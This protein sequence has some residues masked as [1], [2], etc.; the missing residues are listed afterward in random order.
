MMYWQKHKMKTLKTLNSVLFLV[1][2]TMCTDH[3]ISL[4]LFVRVSF[5]SV[6]PVTWRRTSTGSTD[7]VTWWPL[8]SV[9]YVVHKGTAHART[10]CCSFVGFSFILEHVGFDLDIN[11]TQILDNFTMLNKTSTQNVSC[12]I[13]NTW[14]SAYVLIML[15]K[16][17]FIKS[18]IHSLLR[19]LITASEEETQSADHRVLHWCGSGVFQHR[20][21][22]LPHGYHQ[23][24]LDTKTYRNSLFISR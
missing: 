10:L 13:N 5:G 23:W 4:L 19:S 14:F 21:L 8:R 9:W 20:Q 24:V 12:S 7:W 2:T 1:W 11:Q 15:Q 3:V 18:L 6:K 17:V 16:H 22:Q